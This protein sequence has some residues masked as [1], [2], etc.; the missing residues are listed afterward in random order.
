[1]TTGIE[2]ETEAS[3]MGFSLK[4]SRRTT[5]FLDDDLSSSIVQ[6]SDAQWYA[7][8]RSCRQST[9]ESPSRCRK[10]PLLFRAL[11]AARSTAVVEATG[12]QIDQTGKTR[13]V[14]SWSRS[15]STESCQC[16]LL[17]TEVTARK[18]KY[19]W[20]FSSGHCSA[21]LCRRQRLNGTQP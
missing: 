16:W 2:I 10:F 17:P 8:S 11:D 3:V 20:R 12:H 9:R 19:S 4:R 15:A 14:Q 13:A 7:S 21:V 6:E 5:H 1:M 18:K